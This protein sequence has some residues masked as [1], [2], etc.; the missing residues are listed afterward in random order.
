[1]CGVL[2]QKVTLGLCGFEKRRRLPVGVHLQYMH[3]TVAFSWRFELGLGL[4]LFYTRAGFVFSQ[5]PPVL[6]NIL[7]CIHQRSSDAPHSDTQRDAFDTP[8]PHARSMLNPQRPKCRYPQAQSFPA[9]FNLRSA[10]LNSLS[11]SLSAALPRRY[12]SSSNPH[13]SL[14]F[15]FPSSCNLSISSFFRRRSPARRNLGSLRQLARR[16]S[17]LRISIILI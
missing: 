6:Y 11:A 10:S 13:H 8:E 15:R 5:A 2:F 4:G 12:P 9:S 16:N 1:V 14:C 17:V 7:T 3:D